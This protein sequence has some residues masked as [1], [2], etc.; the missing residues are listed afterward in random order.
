MPWKKNNPGD[1]CCEI[2]CRGC[3]GGAPPY[4]LIELIGFKAGGFY[5]PECELLNGSY[6][7]TYGS[8]TGLGYQ[9]GYLCNYYVTIPCT[10]DG[11]YGEVTL[12]CYP[13]NF[14]P[15]H[16]YRVR[17]ILQYNTAIHPT[18]PDTW[19]IAIIEQNDAFYFQQTGSGSLDCLNLDR[20]L[21]PKLF[22]Y[23]CC[24]Q[25]DIECRVTALT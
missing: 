10:V 24:D 25:D 12:P 13:C 6:V 1:P 22:G 19:R 18:D 3:P 17:G 4:L 20:L 16:Y 9:T 11:P 15:D 2:A 5:G 7:L 8:E 23:S 21:I 14:F